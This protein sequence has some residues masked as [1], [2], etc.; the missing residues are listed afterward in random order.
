MPQTMFVADVVTAQF[1]AEEIIEI[2]GGRLAAGMMPDDPAEICTDTRVMSEGAWFLALP[3]KHYDGIDFIGDAFSAGAI[4]CIVTERANYAISSPNFPLIA[5]K[6]PL[7][8]LQDLARNWR[9][10]IGPR[11]VAVTGSLGTGQ[12][13]LAQL[14]AKLLSS[15]RDQVV[16]EI[17]TDQGTAT[18]V[19]RDM[20]DL[21]DDAR[22]VVLDLQPETIEDASNISQALQPNVAIIT[23]GSFSN[24]L[25]EGSA[26]DVIEAQCELLANLDA[27]RRVAIICDPPAEDL[28]AWCE[29]YP[30]T[31]H[32]FNASDVKDVSG[33]G[34]TAIEFAGGGVAGCGAGGAGGSGS[35][36]SGGGGGAL[37]FSV[38]SDV[39]SDIQD[40]WTL[41]SMCRALAMR[42]EAIQEELAAL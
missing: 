40:V 32:M 34:W 35:G 2:T 9:R 18:G 11:V 19:L 27:R 30:G 42:D 31:V 4:G 3:G 8:A 1:S 25:I 17:G 23:K 20:L 13:K 28:G 37:R 22:A 12:S 6:D 33:N 36:G 29:F 7:T 41:V 14:A 10:R 5:V 39:T 24:L 38:R 26:D 16:V 21:P 15:N